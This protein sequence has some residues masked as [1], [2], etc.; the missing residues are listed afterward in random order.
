MRCIAAS[1]HLP[2]INLRSAMLGTKHAVRAMKAA[3]RAGCI[4]NTASIAGFS[5]NL[6]PAGDPVYVPAGGW[7][8][9]WVSFKRCTP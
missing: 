9:V 6:A 8:G 2:Q 3:G 1:L 5:A 4:I 7:M